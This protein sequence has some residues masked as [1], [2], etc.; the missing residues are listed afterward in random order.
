MKGT[1]LYLVGSWP[2]LQSL[3]PLNP[4]KLTQ[5]LVETS[6]VFLH[7]FRNGMSGRVAS[8]GRTPPEGTSLLLLQPTLKQ[9][10]LPSAASRLPSRGQ[11]SKY[12]ETSSHEHYVHSVMKVQKMFSALSVSCFVLGQT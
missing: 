4:L 3:G 5:L 1:N 11:D 12:L 7:K 9:L 10:L 6:K 2:Q 8:P